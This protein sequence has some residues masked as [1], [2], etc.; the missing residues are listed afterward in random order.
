[1][2]V[3]CAR[4]P[5]IYAHKCNRSWC[6]K[7]HQWSSAHFPK[8]RKCPS[9]RMEKSLSQHQPLRQVALRVWLSCKCRYFIWCLIQSSSKGICWQIV[10]RTEGGGQDW[11]H[12][13]FSNNLPTAYLNPTAVTRNSADKVSKGHAMGLAWCEKH[14]LTH[15]LSHL[16][17]WEWP[18]E[19][20]KRI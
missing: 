1:M 8:N 17:H 18:A 3:A 7:D 16:D 4:T 14:C 5:W 2:G 13:L 9:T 6:G 10:P 12:P 11:V 20:F 19:V 15:F